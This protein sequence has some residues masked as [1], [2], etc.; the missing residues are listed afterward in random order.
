MK[1]INVIG[2][3]VLLIAIVLS[4]CGGKTTVGSESFSLDTLT[5]ISIETE[6]NP[7]RIY[8]TD[9]NEVLVSAPGY[10]REWISTEDGRMVVRVPSPAG[11]HL[12][13]PGQ[14][15]IA[16]PEHSSLELS[17]ET[18]S[19]HVS[20]EHVRLDRLNVKTSAGNIKLVG[21]SGHIQAVTAVGRIETNLPIKAS[22]EDNLSG[23]G[24]KLNGVLGDAAAEEIRI[25]DVYTET[26]KINLE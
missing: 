12:K 10:K 8:A 25:V 5:E 7:I 26:G 17:A 24:N 22:I 2:F 19:G 11:I 13:A 15:E 23:V 16:I 18:D 14:V 9:G 3:T 20:I 21:L 1:K 6:G 4:G